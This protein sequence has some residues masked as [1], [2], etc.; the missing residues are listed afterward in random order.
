MPDKVEKSRVIRPAT[1]D[2]SEVLLAWR[3]DP[4]SRRWN[5]T[6]VAVQVD[7]HERW[8]RNRLGRDR[9]L[10]W[11][12]DESGGPIATARLDVGSDGTATVSIAVDQRHRG[13]GVARDV[14]AYLDQ[15]G[16]V[17]GLSSLRA[18]VHPGNSAS[19]ALFVAAGYEKRSVTD[20]G[21]DQYVRPLT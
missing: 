3:N 15:Q 21:F 18:E 14:L 10:L 1:L 13:R 2:D 12:V 6:A 20:D 17:M 9:P 7:E 5:H 4:S 16:R 8:L 11:M 19:Q